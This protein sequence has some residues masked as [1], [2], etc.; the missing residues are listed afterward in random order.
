MLPQ[1]TSPSQSSIPPNA[2]N[3]CSPGATKAGMPSVP[4]CRCRF[5]NSSRS[6]PRGT[7]RL[8]AV[9]PISRTG[10]KRG[11]DR[12][13]GQAV[14]RCPCCS[15]ILGIGGKVAA[16]DWPAVLSHQ[17]TN[18]GRE[19]CL[20]IREDA[21]H[22]CHVLRR[23]QNGQHVRPDGAGPLGECRLLC[24]RYPWI[25]LAQ[26][27]YHERTTLLSQSPLSLCRPG[28]CPQTGFR[29]CPGALAGLT[30]QSVETAVAAML[31]SCV[32]FRLTCSS[33][34]S[35]NCLRCGCI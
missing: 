24:H 1:L 29:P 27:A 26:L 14:Y 9:E 3:A 13:L 11:I 4:S 18:Y 22:P 23:Q 12:R 2:R 15:A 30:R 7:C 28:A 20:A 16:L 34:Q 33:S 25:L 5:S 10:F 8:Y 31:V 17:C 6:M 35:G 19:I 21:F 32:P